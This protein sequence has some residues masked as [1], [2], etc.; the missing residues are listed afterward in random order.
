M[1]D[2]DIIVVGA[3][4]GGLVSCKLAVGMGKRT[5]V[6]EE[7]KIG[8]NCTWYGC[9]PS[10]ALIKSAAVAHK[11]NSLHKFGLESSDQINLRTNNVMQHVRNVINATACGHP[12]ESLEQQ[13]I[14]FFRGAARFLNNHTIDIAERTLTADKFVITTGSRALIPPIKG[15]EKVLYFTNRTTFDIEQLPES[16]LVLGGGPIGIELGAAM[17]RLGVKVTLVEQ[18]DTVLARD[19]QELVAKLV[20]HLEAEGLELLTNMKAV[21]VFSGPGG[22]TAHLESGS[23]T[24][25]I[26]TEAVLVSTGRIPNIDD[27]NLEKASVEYGKT[28]IVVDKHLRTTAKNIYACGDVVPPYLFSHIAEYE[29]VIAVTNACMPVQIQKTDYSNVVWTTFTDPELAHAGL[30]EEQAR[31]KHGDRIRIYRW[32]YKDIDRAKTEVA[33]DGLAK[34]ITDRKGRILGAHVLG[35]NASEVMHEVQFAKSLGFKFQKIASVI[36]SYPSFSDVVR[37]PAKKCRV[38]LLLD[39]PIVKLLRK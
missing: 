34:I 12:P 19:D 16:L 10:K 21:E 20:E 6:V 22:I 28:G 2:Y 32:Q 14:D 36:H 38:D 5:A 17:T 3:G 9:I 23:Q 35:Q 25:T 29:A 26:E 15:I 13:G 11:L 27:L 33:T 31:Q 7:D 37:Q 18:A 8:G 24:R 1:Y 4:A 30:T 39:N